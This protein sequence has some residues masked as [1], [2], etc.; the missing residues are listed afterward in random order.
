MPSSEGCVIYQGED[1]SGWGLNQMSSPW[2]QVGA[3]GPRT[4]QGPAATSMATV[5]VMVLDESTA[6]QKQKWKLHTRSHKE[7]LI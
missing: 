3:P 6:K 7:T 4:S 1:R 2:P 5:V